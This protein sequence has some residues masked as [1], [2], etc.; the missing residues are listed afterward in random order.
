M[1]GSLPLRAFLPSPH[2]F[3]ARA[4]QRGR[5]ECLMHHTLRMVGLMEEIRE[6]RAPIYITY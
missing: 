4:R 6:N 2:L 1:C 5:N 3:R